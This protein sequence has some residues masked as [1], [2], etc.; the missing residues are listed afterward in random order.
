M[1]RA[2]RT[3]ALASSVLVL[4]SLLVATRSSAATLVIPGT[5]NVFGAGHATPPAPDGGGGGTLPP[6]FALPAGTS[7]ALVFSNV[8]GI[9]HCCGGLAGVENG[10]DGGPFGGP[11]TDVLSYGGISGIYHGQKTLFLVGVFLDDSEPVDPAPSRL[12]F[13]TGYV[14]DGFAQISPQLRQVFF[15][16]DGL[17]GTGIGATQ[18]FFVPDGAT[19]LFLGF[20][21]SF[22]FGHPSSLPGWYDDN[23]GSLSATLDVVSA[24]TS[25]RRCPW[26]ALKLRYR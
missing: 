5:A 17:R 7:R 18:A 11:P 23:L 14:S 8:T 1:P 10:P 26:G 21:D 4:S 3:L 12:F 24:T 6:L 9:V 15:I 20:A 19:R 13:G 2:G 25:V 22:D 16:G